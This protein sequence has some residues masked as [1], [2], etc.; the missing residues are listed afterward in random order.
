MPPGVVGVEHPYARKLLQLGQDLCVEEQ[1][2][3]L[4]LEA[5]VEGLHLGVVLG[6]ALVLVTTPSGVAH[7]SAD[8]W[9][10]AVRERSLPEH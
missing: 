7:S 10:A 9:R 3:V 8:Y 5:A 2:P 4:G 1:R 6:A